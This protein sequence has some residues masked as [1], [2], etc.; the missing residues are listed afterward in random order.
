[1]QDS[2]PQCITPFARLTTML[3]TGLS[4]YIVTGAEHSMQM[5]FP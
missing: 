4:W 2:N 1:M 3:G 5:G